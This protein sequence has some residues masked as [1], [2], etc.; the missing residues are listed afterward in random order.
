M[1]SQ[2]E[3]LRLAAH[4]SRWTDVGSVSSISKVQPPNDLSAASQLQ[5]RHLSSITYKRWA[6]LLPPTHPRPVKAVRN[7]TSFEATPELNARGSFLPRVPVGGKRLIVRS[8][9]T[10]FQAKRLFDLVV[11]CRKLNPS[12]ISSVKSSVALPLPEGANGREGSRAT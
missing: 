8:C 3:V 11:T 5:G 9:S 2:D 10:A 7:L 4:D 12:A 1:S 6:S